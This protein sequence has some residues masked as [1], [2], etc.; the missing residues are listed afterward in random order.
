MTYAVGLCDAADIRMQ[1]LQA[2]RHHTIP[3]FD[4]ERSSWSSNILQ[5]VDR[6]SPSVEAGQP[7]AQL[8]AQILAEWCM[9]DAS[10][11]KVPRSHGINANILH[12]RGPAIT[13]AANE[14]AEVRCR[15]AWIGH[16]S[17]GAKPLTT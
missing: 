14:T 4:D 12:C 6:P 1:S 3:S 10:V 15:P 7:A 11:A 8:K 16:P 5:A 2:A 13:P 17:D 9:P